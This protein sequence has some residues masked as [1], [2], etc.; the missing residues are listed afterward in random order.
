M[1]THEFD[2]A[3][4]Q[5]CVA[6][7]P[8]SALSA[9]RHAAAAEFGQ[10]GF[11]TTRHEDWRYTNL[12]PAIAIQQKSLLERERG[13]RQLNPV[14]VIDIVE[15]CWIRF[16]DGEFSFPLND[17]PPGV[18]IN[19]LA[20]SEQASVIDVKNS[21][22]QINAALLRDALHVTIAAGVTIDRPIGLLFAEHSES[23]ALANHARVIISVEKDASVQILEAQLSS[24]GGDVYINTVTQLLLANNANVNYVRLQD[25]ADHHVQT[26]RLIANIGSRA[27]LTHLAFDLGAQLA[28]NDVEVALNDSDASVTLNGLYLAD[29]AQ[30]IDN[31]TRV[32]HAAGPS[33]SEELY[34]GILN[35][36]SR[37]VFNGKA[38]VHEGADGTDAAQANHNLLLSDDAEV[39]TKPE[40]E[41]YADDVKCSHGA[42]VGQ[43]DANALFYLRTRGLD[44]ETAKHAITKA[45]AAEIVE[46]IAPSQIHD[47]IQSRV[48]AKLDQLTAKNQ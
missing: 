48:D 26:N 3:V 40:L 7:I 23:P 42:T 21:L 28:R 12:A 5:K 41:I 37:C 31:H 6:S 44:E 27:K 9:V 17:L 47:Y 8:D 1:T 24:G 35:G 2:Q 20:D 15:A 11:P 25:C 46:T 18:T 36:K 43:L 29:G 22:S 38:V 4:F 45:F 14:D 13:D 19:R 30:H 10:S 39:D 34:R 32:D 33:F 16:D